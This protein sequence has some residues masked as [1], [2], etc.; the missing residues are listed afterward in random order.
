MGTGV[1]CAMVHVV[2]DDVDTSALVL[3]AVADDDML[4]LNAC[5]DGLGAAVL[6]ILEEVDDVNT[7]VLFTAGTSES[8]FHWL[9]G[10]DAL[11]GSGMGSELDANSWY[12]LTILSTSSSATKLLYCNAPGWTCS[13]D[14]SDG[15]HSLGSWT[16]A[17]CF[18]ISPAW[19]VTMCCDSG[20]HLCTDGMQI[21]RH[22]K[23][24]CT[25]FGSF[26]H[27]SLQ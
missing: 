17:T 8:V 16:F 9:C 1:D 6:V 11:S 3:T 26:F 21:F 4:L 24:C 14:L 2:L 19:M 20:I 5:V 27:I 12:H 13:H 15:G 10:Y 23:T 18:M 7:S 25:K 22:E